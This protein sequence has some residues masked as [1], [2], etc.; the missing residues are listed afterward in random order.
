[1]VIL[2][3]WQLEVYMRGGWG[4]AKNA[5]ICLS[6]ETV[7]AGQ[8]LNDFHHL[9]VSFQQQISLCLRHA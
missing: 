6:G 4:R 2:T 8:N 9:C 3:G 5:M 1:M 7:H